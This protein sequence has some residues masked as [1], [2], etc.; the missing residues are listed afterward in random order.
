MLDYETLGNNSDTITLSL[1]IV[2]FN[3]TGIIGETLI[4][5]D[6]DSQVT[7]GRTFTASTLQWWMNQSEQ[8]RAVFQP[9]GTEVTLADFFA[10]F[11][12][13]IKRDLGKIGERWDEVKLWGNGANFD[14]SITEDLYRRHHPKRDR[15][16]P[17]K[18][19]NTMCF[20]TFD[21]LTQC[22]KLH[23]RP[24]GTHHSALDDARY[25]AK[26]VLA[27]WNRPKKK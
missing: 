10:V 24:H 27:H 22:K 18:F 3:K 13:A 4:K 9:D 25:Q 15:G 6:L 12:G 14:V 5:L 11:E 8:A 2:S 21:V 7:A 23:G 16:I 17:W 26:C 1:G 20:R 19:W